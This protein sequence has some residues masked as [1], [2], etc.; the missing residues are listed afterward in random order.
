MPREPDELPPD[1]NDALRR[2]YRRPVEV[3]AEIDAAI[4]RSAEQHLSRSRRRRILAW[5]SAAAA[6]LVAI[7]ILIVMQSTS[8]PRPVAIDARPALT[9]DIRDA[10]ALA[11]QGGTPAEVDRL[12]RQAVKLPEVSR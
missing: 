11:R 6:A 3:P 4:G 10:F 1:I 5:C 7:S 12:A 9:G 8:S 2:V